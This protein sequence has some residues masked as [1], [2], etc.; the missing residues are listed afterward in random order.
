LRSEKKNDSLRKDKYVKRKLTAAAA[1]L[2]SAVLTASCAVVTPETT[3]A[4]ES[5]G[6]IYGTGTKTEQTSSA[7]ATVGTEENKTAEE[8]GN[9]PASSGEK[10]KETVTD[11]N[12][13]GFW[14]N[15]STSDTSVIPASFERAGGKESDSPF[16]FL[17][18][19]ALPDLSG[20]GM[21]GVIFDT[22]GNML[23]T[24][25]VPSFEDGGDDS[26]EPRDAVAVLTDLQSGKQISRKTVKEN[27]D[28]YF[29]SDGRICV[30]SRD[31]GTAAIFDEKFD[32]ALI[33]F[34][35]SSYAE[36]DS[37][38]DYYGA[39]FK[40]LRVSKDGK[41]IVAFG[42]ENGIVIIDI[43]T[44]KAD[45]IDAE[46]G[47]V[48]F[49]TERNGVMYFKQLGESDYV[50]AVDVSGKKLSKTKTDSGFMIYTDTAACFDSPL[51]GF[52]APFED[53]TDI[54]FAG[55][56]DGYTVDCLEG[57]YVLCKGEYGKLLYIADTAKNVSAFADAGAMS[58]STLL[59]TGKLCFG[60]FLFCCE[61]FEKGVCFMFLDLSALDWQ[62][63]GTDYYMNGSFDAEEKI[64]E[65]V[66][67]ISDGYGVTVLYGEDGVKY[68]KD[69]EK[70]PAVYS[71]G[72]GT[73]AA[74][75]ALRGALKEYP[76]GI[77]RE[78]QTGGK[79]LSV[80][81]CTDIPAQGDVFPAGLTVDHDGGC[82]IVLDAYYPYG[83][84][85]TFSHEFMHVLELYTIPVK[86]SE[87]YNYLSAWYE[88]QPGED[89][90]VK[91][92]SGHDPDD[93]TFGKW[94]IAD[95]DVWFVNAYSRTNASEDKAELFAWLMDDETD[96]DYLRCKNLC[97]KARFLCSM[98]R[99][100]ME[101]VRNVDCAPWERLL[102]KRGYDPKNP[103]EE[104][105][106][107]LSRHAR[108]QSN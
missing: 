2:L 74:V 26:D 18:G 14:K 105:R 10:T 38:G 3:G 33:E 98:I 94:D 40:R 42:H 69:A 25:G 72:Y 6:D 107:L 47:Y 13:V 70:H 54:A 65:A 97:R 27:F 37:Y 30:S 44:K 17:Y 55:H 77:F 59:Y 1:L 12:S 15:R 11:G 63:G 28:V 101:S 88:L 100:N 81:L 68:E 66:R 9:G 19:D 62:S 49:V 5:A 43:E 39:A 36:S 46:H 32:K 67:E 23:L 64:K 31:T 41:S 96:G 56:P 86:S 78:A 22:Y 104:F 93:Y 92:G 82:A 16:Y 8:T 24:V 21:Y 75:I 102:L 85:R 106:D 53:M 99:D 20:A 52:V 51:F 79:M 71:D 60:G 108:T 90:Y 45:R 7:F 91:D 57:G 61:D 50:L 103:A 48:D 76:E 80:F 89:A 29:L 4:P 34:D 84:K 83:I 58:F 35:A 87:T 95:D 73:L